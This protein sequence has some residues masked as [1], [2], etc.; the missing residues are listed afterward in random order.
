MLDTGCLY[1]NAE[2]EATNGRPPE[3]DLARPRARGAAGAGPGAGATALLRGR[4]RSADRLRPRPARERE[5]VA[6]GRA[7]AVG[8]LPLHH[9]RPAARLARAADGARGR[10]VAGRR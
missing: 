5:P 9:A 4:R 7:E 8:R 2:R 10:P 6:P 3:G 1:V